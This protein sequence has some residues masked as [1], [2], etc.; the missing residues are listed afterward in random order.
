LD[1]RTFF[2][3][4][5]KG[6]SAS[7][8]KA[9]EAVE[10]PVL[11]LAVPGSGKTTVLLTR[12]GYMTLCCAVSPAQ[13][14]TMTYTVAATREMKQRFS[15]MF[16]EELGEKVEF[17]TINGVASKII[18]YYSAHY[19]K[20]QVFSL[21]EKE[22][23]LNRI[24][25]DLGKE[26]T[27]EFWEEAAVKEVRTAI[28]LGKNSM[29]QPEQWQELEE[30]V[31]HI[32]KLYE[33]YT[34]IM[35][36]RRWMDYDDQLSY[37]YTILKNYPPVLAAFQKQYR[38][39]CVDESQDTSKIQH[40]IIAL[41]AGETGNL[42]MVGDEDQSI[43]GFRA[44]Y[45]QA[46]LDFKKDHPG[47]KV[48]LMEENYRSV[49]EIV[50]LAGKFVKK[51][52]YRY[53]KDLRAVRGAGKPLQVIETRDRA[54]QYRYL[55][56]E[57]K[58]LPGE[59][60]VLYR[61][62]DS[63]LPL[64][65]DL[66]RAGIPY[67]CR[68]FDQVFFTHPVVHDIL[69]FLRLAYDGQN[70]ESFLRIYY[71]MD[72]PIS[73]E[74]ALFAAAQSEKTGK[75]LWQELQ[76]FGGLHHSVRE[77]LSQR[78]EMFSLLPEDRGDQA[79]YRI[80]NAM[81]YGKYGEEKKLDLGKLEILA[82]LGRREDSPKG[83]LR[84]LEEL[85]RLLSQEK[86]EEGIILTTIHSSKGLE[87]DRVFLIDVF[88]GIFPARQLS[89]L[90]SPQEQKE[91]EEERRLFYVAMTRAKEEL[92]LFSCERKPSVFVQEAMDLVPRKVREKGDFF[93]FLE[94]GACGKLYF[95]ETL[96][97]GRITAQLGETFLV[98]FENGED[99]RFSFAEMAG[100]RDKTLRFTCSVEEERQQKIQ[101][102]ESFSKQDTA[103][104][105]AG[106]FEPGDLVR[107]QLF[108]KGRVESIQ[109]DVLSV[110]FHSSPQP[111]RFSLQL[112]L[113]NRYL[114]KLGGSH[115]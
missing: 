69:D 114:E 110:L 44:A 93:S 37:A 98:S 88:D 103:F 72:L 45:P 65:D 42:F 26:I 102:P 60:A 74:A 10:G 2:E 108:G 80:W 75:P 25:R 66:E 3:T 56:W 51:N 58:H 39:I 62:N 49:Q 43:Y 95:H 54:A 28:T 12:L 53:E 50:D 9:V 79:V 18:A 11:L 1:K 61:N 73:K 82:L 6:L 87:Y 30:Q 67:R 4:Y 17:R 84:R 113:K 107:H 32:R 105:D 38:Y 100:Q 24:I 92:Y 63:A 94:E 96:G 109:G 111:K 22:G 77:R 48:L 91:Y 76:R 115:G 41:L 83:L 64:I 90:M 16:G 59:T 8:K 27:G 85:R 23:E 57:A 99:K 19:G 104:E 81:G 106:H 78:G 15:A 35:K 7:Q 33:G 31:P 5:G 36:E 89:D 97:K 46:L 20:G 55:F 86:Q 29:F 112:T 13:I 71:K 34:R 47:A 68:K 14:L 52:R 21:Q 40:A 101:M 70:T